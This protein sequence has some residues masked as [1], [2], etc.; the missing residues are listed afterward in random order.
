M[1]RETLVL[2]SAICDKCGVRFAEGDIING[3]QHKSCM[4]K[5]QDNID[6]QLLVIDLGDSC[7]VKVE[8]GDEITANFGTDWWFRVTDADIVRHTFADIRAA[9]DALEEKPPVPRIAVN[10]DVGYWL[11]RED[12][13]GIGWPICKSQ[14]DILSQLAGKPLPIWTPKKGEWEPLTESPVFDDL[15]C[16]IWR[17]TRRAND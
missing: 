9:I 1:S 6:L 10:G 7:V 11:F 14:Y 8:K 15:P 13:D 2:T 17:Y 16:E 3:W 4:N 12:G 5:E